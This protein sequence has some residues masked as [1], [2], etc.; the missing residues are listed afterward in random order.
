MGLGSGGALRESQDWD[1]GHGVFWGKVRGDTGWGEWDWGQGGLGHTVG[2]GGDVQI[3]VE[4][5][6]R[7]RRNWGVGVGLGCGDR[8]RGTLRGSGSDP[9][10][11]AK[12]LGVLR[13]IVIMG[14]GLG[15]W[16]AMALWDWRPWGEFGEAKVSHQFGMRCSVLLARSASLLPGLTPLLS[17]VLH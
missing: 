15:F 2:V 11:W 13:G 3:W 7:Q 10:I 9:R 1:W 17:P 8:L 6:G 16:G 12:V 5:V 4:V 14:V